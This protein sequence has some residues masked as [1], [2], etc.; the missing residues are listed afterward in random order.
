VAKR[1]L[2]RLVRRLG[3]A[4]LV[5]AVDDD[6]RAFGDAQ[7]ATRFELGS[8]TKTFTARL[9]EDLAEEGVV[10]LDEP[11]ADLLGPGWRLPRG[12][13]LRRLAEHRSGLPRLGRGILRAGL[14]SPDDPYREVDLEL[15]RR[16]L[17]ALPRP[18]WRRYSN[19]GF[20]LLGAALAARTGVPWAELVRT[21]ITEPLGLHDTG[22]DGPVAQPHRRDGTPTP[23]WDLG[24]VAPAGAL[25]GTAAD[26]VAYLAAPTSGLGWVRGDEGRWHNGGTGGSAA[27]AG[28][29]ARTGRRV[30][31]LASAERP[32][33][34]TSA[35]LALLRD[36]R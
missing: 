17:P 31:L 7:P 34:V 18:R 36:G 33:E 12:V 5:V 8:I 15:L 3:P 32:A 23:A 2:D 24:A 11:A 1:P 4:G 9:L 35:G 21:R 29:D 19:L 10:G 6:V 22:P 13:T 28:V 16:S 27:F 25:R 14:R 20:A 30:V 26:L